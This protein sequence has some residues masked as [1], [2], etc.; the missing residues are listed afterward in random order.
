[1]KLY[2]MRKFS[3]DDHLKSISPIGVYWLKILGSF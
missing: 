1:M 2:F 3:P